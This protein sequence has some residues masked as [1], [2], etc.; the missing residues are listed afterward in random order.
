[1]KYEGS[2]TNTKDLTNKQ[3][4]DAKASQVQNLIPTIVDN[5]TTDDGTK[6]LSAKQ[7]KVLN[8]K[9]L[10]LPQELNI[11][12]VI[13][14]L[15]SSSTTDALSAKQGKVLDQ[16]ITDALGDIDAVLQNIVGEVLS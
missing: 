4:V 8:D 2:V 6:A 1:M 3:Y 14:S 15:D 12:N 13:D 7:G 5:L 16:K 9:I 11:P 10:A